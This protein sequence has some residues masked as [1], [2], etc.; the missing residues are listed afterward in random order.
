MA[1]GLLKSVSKRRSAKNGDIDDMT[2]ALMQSVGGFIVAVK[3]L[4]GDILS[5]VVANGFSN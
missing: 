3:N 5:E 1:S 2:A 4:E